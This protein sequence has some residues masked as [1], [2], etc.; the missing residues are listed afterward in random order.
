MSYEKL[1]EHDDSSRH[2]IVIASYG[3]GSQFAVECESCSTVLV[4]F[5]SP[6]DEAGD[7]V[8]LCG[9]AVATESCSYCATPKL[10]EENPLWLDDE[11]QFARLLCELRANWSTPSNYEDAAH[12]CESMD[13]TG[14]EVEGLFDRAH[15][16]W[17]AAKDETIDA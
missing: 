12:L 8:Y 14:A 3:D 1:K 5:D 9:H 4:S 2:S 10:G 13:L 6:Q 17:E 16:K 11:V 7:L 15:V